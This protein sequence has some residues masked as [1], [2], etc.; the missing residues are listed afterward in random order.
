MLFVMVFWF[1]AI[2]FSTNTV[3]NAYYIPEKAVGK[4]NYECT[5]CLKKYYML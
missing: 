3:T 1:P 4:G 5:D 2:S